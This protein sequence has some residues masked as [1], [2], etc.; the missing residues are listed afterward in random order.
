MV[1]LGYGWQLQIDEGSEWLFFRLLQT[2]F[3]S[4]PPRPLAE[5]LWAIASE[6]GKNRLVLELA[7][8]ALLTSYI[9]GQLA[10]LHKRVMLDGGVLR[11][12]GLSDDNY[13]VL[14]M[15]RLAERFPNYRTREA[16][17]MGWQPPNRPR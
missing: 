15:M 14:Q 17:V 5:V 8:G 2:S 6:R 3:E 16:A 4:E 1:E 11:L 10:I 13:R 9:I 12:C 7:Q